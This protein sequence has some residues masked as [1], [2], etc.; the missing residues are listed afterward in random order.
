MCLTD[1]F[2]GSPPLNEAKAYDAWYETAKGKAILATEVEALRPLIEALPQPR[3]EVGVGTGRFAEAVGARFGL[4]PSREA[5]RLARARGILAVVGSGE[6]VPFAGGRFGTVLIAFTLCFLVD[7]AA[8]LL[9]ARRLLVDGGG[10][11]IGFLPRET[12]W[13]DLYALRGRQGHP[14][15]RHARFYAVAEVEQLL[16]KSGLRVVARR[17]TL[18]QPPDLKRYEVEP[19]SDGVADD[20]GFVAISAVKQLG[21]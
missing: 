1:P 4:D 8:T 17:S 20:A 14:I 18:R 2:G 15:Y 11:A 10:L 6:V 21:R 13:A 3:V 12:P 5:L 9:E 16:T 19:A 7:P